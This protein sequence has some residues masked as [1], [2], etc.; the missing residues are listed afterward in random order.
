MK[1]FIVSSDTLA[2]VLEKLG[3][4]VGGS[5]I[6]PILK[7]IVCKVSKDEIELITTDM[8]ITMSHTCAAQTEGA[9]FDLLLPYDFVNSICHLVDTMPL[10]IEHPSIRK[11]RILAEGEVYE[12]NSL[13]KIEEFPKLPSVPKKNSI[14]LDASFVSL[15]NKAM[16]TVSKEELRPAMTRAC[17]DI[18][19]NDSHL[20]STDAHCL[21]KH[22]VELT[23][24]EPQQI[25][26]SHKMAK[27][28][29]GLQEL[30][31][32]WNNNMV[33][34]KSG[35]IIVWAKRHEEKYPNYNAIIP[36]FSPNL[37]IEKSR[38]VDAL[39]KACLSSSAN[40]HTRINLK[41][42]A[43]EIHFEA[44]DPDYSRKINLHVAG[45]YTG[46]V[47]AVSINAKLML[48]ILKQVDTDQISL[49]IHH[50]KKAILVSTGDN[51]DYLGLL[52]PIMID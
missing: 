13:D 41:K 17:L 20:V 33:S 19:V 37:V 21:F 29:D 45:D 26:F 31:V 34:I 44:D 22:R 24:T 43:G 18:T 14:N 4:A 39:N 12:L 2:P 38:L 16:L 25:S 51:K 50:P 6:L 47:E 7:N 28:I 36:D 15:L 42:K 27:A 49:S 48:T 8:E 1:K 23:A 3:R 10:V 35:Q 46:N 32:N 5:K 40:K 52:M 11:A 9:P 30:E